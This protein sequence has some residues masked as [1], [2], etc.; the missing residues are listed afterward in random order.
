MIQEVIDH[1]FYGEDEEDYYNDDGKVVESSNNE[2]GTDALNQIEEDFQ[3]EMRNFDV[4]DDN[5]HHWE[6]QMIQKSF[7]GW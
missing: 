5:I 7:I 4:S 3:N 6:V 2:R 1:F